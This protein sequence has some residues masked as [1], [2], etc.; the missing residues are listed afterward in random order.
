MLDVS[1]SGRVRKKNS[2][3]AAYESLDEVDKPKKKGE[4]GKR[5]SS[6]NQKVR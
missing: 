3:L 4:R 2:L 5:R 1:R 6:S